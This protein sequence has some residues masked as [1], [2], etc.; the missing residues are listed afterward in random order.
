MAAAPSPSSAP[1]A[2]TAPASAPHAA[3][4][5][6][7]GLLLRVSAMVYDGVLLFGVLFVVSYALLASLG[8]SAP[9]A[10][11]QRWILQAALFLAI[12]AYF[13]WSWSRGGQTL[14]LKTWRLR[15]VG[16]DAAP[17]SLP[18]ALARY[19][20]AWHLFVPGLLAIAWLPL[21]RGSAA[22]ALIASLLL[23]LT[24]ALFDRERRLLH[25]RWVGT[26]IVRE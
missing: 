7:A 22:L 10:A 15:L 1:A 5:R 12:G 16:P 26:R 2:P 24:P 19:V 25:D 13:A 21:A 18:R 14:A 20:L 3:H 6:P 17:P 4:E 11:A 23:L 9:L 8:W